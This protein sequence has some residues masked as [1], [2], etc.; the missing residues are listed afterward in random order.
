MFPP[1]PFE[2]LNETDI[3]EEVIA[4]L[5]RRLGYQSGATNNIIREQSL[6]YPHLFLGRKDPKKDPELRGKADYILEVGG[7]LR[8]VIEA[9]SPE[10]AIDVE[11]IEQGWT[12]SNHPEVRA[13]YFVISTGR[14]LSV[15]R[16]TDG[17][18]AGPVLSLAYEEL[19]TKFQVLANVLSPE[20]IARDFP[21]LEVDV[22]LPIARGLRSLARI[23]N[24]VIRYERNS[25][26]SAPLNELQV[27]ITFGAI[28]RDENGKLVAFL[29]T[30]VPIRSLQELNERLGL[31]QFEMVSDDTQLSEDC[32]RPTV[33]RYEN[34]IVL[35]EGEEVLDISTW[36]KLRLLKNI[37]CDVSATAKGCCRAGAFAGQFVSLL[38]YREF[39]LNVSLEGSFEVHLA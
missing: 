36:R 21:S 6:R 16:T 26:N 2:K 1:L 9:K 24:G 22:G 19:D 13:V 29:K 11:A 17:P 34:T 14:R 4:P 10:V 30:A 25:L 32:D 20:A 35:P 38:W 28:E 12:Y 27:G 33:L 18:N 39:G 8:W 15:F 7:R 37:T 3:R 31:S 23:T 5:L